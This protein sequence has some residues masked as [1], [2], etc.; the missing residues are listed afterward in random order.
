MEEDDREVTLDDCWTLDL[1][2]L[3]EWVPVIEGTMAQQVWKGDSESEMSEGL[4]DDEEDDDM[5]EDEDDELEDI[6]E[7]DTAVSRVQ[8]LIQEK[9]GKKKS[10][11][12]KKVLKAELSELKDQLDLGNANQTPA[13]GENLRDF[14]ERTTN[15]WAEQVWVLSMIENDECFIL[16]RLLHCLKQ[17]KRN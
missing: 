9:D 13:V 11:S 15:Y 3:E 14:F 10:K 7:Q 8:N 1:K 16:Y 12:K 6:S 17:W 2:R 4:D 5:F